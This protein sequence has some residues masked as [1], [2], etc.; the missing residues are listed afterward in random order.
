ML[1]TKPTGPRLTP[2][3]HAEDCPAGIVSIPCHAPGHCHQ[4]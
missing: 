3:I 1:Q 4:D 2:K